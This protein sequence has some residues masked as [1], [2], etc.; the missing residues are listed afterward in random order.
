M[1]LVLFYIWYFTEYFF[2]LIQF[3]DHF[4]GYYNIS[5]EREAFGNEHE[6]DYLERRKW[7]AFLRYL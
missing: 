2:R 6:L 7:W 5:F 3:G 4:A 1:G